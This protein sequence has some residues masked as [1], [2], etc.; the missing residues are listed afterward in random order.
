MGVSPKPSAKTCDICSAPVPHSIGYICVTNQVI[1]K[2][3]YWAD[4]FMTAIPNS[5]FTPLQKGHW[6]AE[7]AE[8]VRISCAWFM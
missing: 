8:N 4:Y 2:R 1:T 7:H 5:K 3:T 6:T